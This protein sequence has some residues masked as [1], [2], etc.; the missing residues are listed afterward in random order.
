M[1]STTV[2][3]ILLSC[4]SF[5][6]HFTR[7]SIT[8]I[9][10]FMISDQFITP[11]GFGILIGAY[12]LPSLFMPIVTGYNIDQEHKEYCITFLMFIF[13]IGGLVLFCVA[14]FLR[15]FEFAFFSMTIFGIGACSLTIVQRMLITV[16]FKVLLFYKLYFSILNI[17]TLVFL[18]VCRKILRLPRDA[19]SRLP[20]LQSFVEK[21]LSGPL[22]YGLFASRILFSLFVS[23]M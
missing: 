4:V 22:W 8:I 10:L 2:N 7:S 23:K 21:C 11:G 17:V 14:L 5:G 18:L 9:S 20:T 6:G 15:S 12:S 16:H 3:L 13:E 19:M 1:P